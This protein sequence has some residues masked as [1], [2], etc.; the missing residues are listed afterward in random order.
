MLELQLVN[1]YPPKPFR[2]GAMSYPTANVDLSRMS[3]I[4]DT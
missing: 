2:E 1:R 4:V 3:I